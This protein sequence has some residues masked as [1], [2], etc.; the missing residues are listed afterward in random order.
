MLIATL[1]PFKQLAAQRRPVGPALPASGSFLVGRVF[2]SECQFA[3]PAQYERAFWFVE[4]R[5]FPI[6][7]VGIGFVSNPEFPEPTVGLLVREPRQSPASFGEGHTIPAA[8]PLESAG[9]ERDALP[10]LVA[11]RRFIEDGCVAAAREMLSS[12]PGYVLSDPLVA[13]LRSVVAPPVVTPTRNLDVDR[14]LEYEWLQTEGYKYRGRW[15][16]LE[17]NNLLATGATLREVRELLKTLVPARP[18]LLH[19]LD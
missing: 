4:A 3:L 15:V 10:F 1:D 9:Q 7:K 19:R 5:R 17:G 8:R 14:T 13:R 11:A 2:H 18:P 16:A 6:S 12:A